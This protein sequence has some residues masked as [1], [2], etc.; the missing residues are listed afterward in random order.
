MTLNLK[1]QSKAI[2]AT[3]N[4]NEP[5]CDNGITV[6]Q[7]KQCGFCCHRTTR[8]PTYIET[9]KQNAFKL[10]KNVCRFSRTISS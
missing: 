8:S 5:Y 4:V 10:F 6:Q 2:V 9:T 7:A 1:P 3:A